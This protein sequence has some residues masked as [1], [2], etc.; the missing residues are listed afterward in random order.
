M[1]QRFSGISLW[2][3]SCVFFSASAM[4]QSTHYSV[5]LQPD[6]DRQL[7]RGDETIEFQADAGAVEWQKQT[8]LR[9]V[10]AN[11]AD[12]DVTVA[13]QVVTVRLRSSGKHTLNLKYTA[14]AGRGIKWLAERAGLVTAFYCEAWMVCDNSPGQ[15]AT[16]RLEIAVP[17]SSPLPLGQNG[18][19]AVGPG[20]RGTERRD[21]DRDYFEFEQSE[22]VQT[23]LFSFGIA[24][25]S[26]A[27]D[28]MFSIYSR[29][30]DANKAAFS[31]TADAYGFLRAAASVD[32]M[33]AHY[34]QAF[35]PGPSMG[36]EA[37]GMALMSQD[38]LSDLVDRDDVQLMAHEMAHQW[39]G[40]TV[41]IRSWSDFW[42]N[43][44]F[45]EFMSDAYIE[46][47]Q[48]RAAYDK[49][50]AQLQERMKKLREAGKDRPLHWEDWKDA[51]EALGPIPYVK[52][53]LFLN[54]LRTE[55]G[56]DT[57]WRGVGLYASSNARR[58]VDS[59]D[60]ERAMEK[61]SGRDLKTLFEE[62]VFH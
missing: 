34:T 62:A 27:V 14:A 28:G 54:R 58:L 35:L 1:P 53:A 29:R 33:N 61:A 56:D 45:A 59:S 5:K 9:V 47:H 7:L 26:V 18:F 17:L 8:G 11:I 10:A 21:A 16:L 32:P 22:P 48:G 60:F 57:F 19:R 20:L 24:R 49:Q 25:V 36:Q 12:G 43:E 51:H 13:E 46:K 50:I 42:L 38:D 39:W 4:A 44:G 41:G 37:A 52:G 15:R 23:Y 40:V 31:K 2:C 6:F 55:L 30:M 3:F